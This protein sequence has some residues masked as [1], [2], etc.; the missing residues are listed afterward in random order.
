MWRQKVTSWLYTKTILS[1]LDQG[2]LSTNVFKTIIPHTF[3]IKSKKY[4]IVNSINEVNRV[5]DKH[6]M[7][8]LT[9]PRILQHMEYANSIKTS[10]IL[11]NF[12]R[13]IMEYF[14]SLNNVITWL[15]TCNWYTIHNKVIKIISRSCVLK[16]NCIRIF[17]SSYK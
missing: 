6:M 13:L 4:A 14:S 9:K 11:K 8:I 10:R 12:N 15:I 1:K 7:M 3:K 17:F 2:L 16:C 5:N